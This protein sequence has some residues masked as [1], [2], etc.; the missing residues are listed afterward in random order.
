MTM[1]MS[2]SAR[3]GPIQINSWHYFANATLIV[4]RHLA[5]HQGD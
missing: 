2:P 4:K 5:R 3:L 1:L